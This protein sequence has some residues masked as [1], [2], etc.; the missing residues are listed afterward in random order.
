M[1]TIH[2]QDELLLHISETIGK[3]KVL[4]LTDI[5][6]NRKF[7]IGDL[8]NLT[9]YPR[10][11]IAFRAAWILENLILLHPVKYVNDIETI[12]AQFTRVNN[13]SCLRHYTKIIMHL[14]APGADKQIKTKL[15]SIN[16]ENVIERCFELLIDRGSPVAVKAFASQVLFNLRSRHTWIAGVLTDQ[17]KIM[18]DGGEP[19]IRA[20]GRKLLSYLVCD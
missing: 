19:A 1:E 2:N 10:K 20:K 5:L 9:F 11:E 12:C 6:Y 17:I 16:M 4:K 7:A 14:T 18:M 13:K 3:N 8:I 15:E